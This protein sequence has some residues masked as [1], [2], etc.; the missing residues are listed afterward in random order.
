MEGVALS[1]AHSW[2]SAPAIVP[3]FRVEANLEQLEL[4][5]IALGSQ[6]V[7]LIKHQNVKQLRYVSFYKFA[8]SIIF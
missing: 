7:V 8:Y 2:T 5:L 1:A 3:I 4:V 6:K